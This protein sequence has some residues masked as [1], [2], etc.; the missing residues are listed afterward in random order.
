MVLTSGA[1]QQLVFSA[2]VL[3]IHKAIQVMCQTI[4]FSVLLKMVHILH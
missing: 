3:S 4:Q 1:H 2:Q